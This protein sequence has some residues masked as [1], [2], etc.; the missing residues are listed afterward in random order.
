MNRKQIATLWV[1]MAL[2][3]AMAMF[4]PWTKG[5]TDENPWLDSGGHFPPVR[6][7]LDAGYRPIFTPPKDDPCIDPGRLGLQCGVVILVT[8]G[9]IWTLGNPRKPKERTF[10]G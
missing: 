2:I 4:P 9:L 3:I 5:Y 6:I 8:A 7:R 1:G 10:G